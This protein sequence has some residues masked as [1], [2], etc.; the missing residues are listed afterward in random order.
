MLT[1]LSALLWDRDVLALTLAALTFAE[2]ADAQF[3]LRKA[4]SAQTDLLTIAQ[5]TRQGAFRPPLNES[6]D[7]TYGGIAYRASSDS[8]FAVSGPYG[9]SLTEISIPTLSMSTTEAVLNR[10]DRLQGPR[11]PF[12]GRIAE[13]K[14]G[15]VSEDGQMVATG[16][17]VSGSTL[18]LSGMRYYGSA[19]YSHFTRSTNLTTTTLA[20]GPMT[21]SHPL[22][23]S[24]G[25]GA[26]AEIP[27]GWR[28]ALGNKDTLSGLGPAPIITRTSQGPALFA[29]NA[30]DMI[31][32]T[33]PVPSVPLAYYTGAHPT[34]GTYQ[35]TCGVGVMYC[36][37]D[38]V[39]GIAFIDGTDTVAVI[40]QHTASDDYCYGTGTANPLLEGEPVG[41]GSFYCYD[42][43]DASKGEHGYP[44]LPWVWLY[45][46]NDLAQAAS[47]A[48]DPW[49]VVP[50]ESGPLPSID[51]AY[52]FTIKP[53]IWGVGY[54]RAGKRLFIA[55]SGGAGAQTIFH[56][57]T[58]P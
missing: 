57:V 10:A 1:L 42:P 27:A 52:P 35:G 12:E 37:T 13:L 32:G 49:D 2:P 54:D 46:A 8:L 34:L 20:Q 11:S 21:V 48:I 3:R 30:S 6:F 50:Y 16:V 7:Y 44:Y 40:G 26:M 17:L 31:A 29:W 41:D 22:N 15:Y 5:L 53:G 28:A 25:A 9:G 36:T 33:T 38:V 58:H 23:A 19:D 47:G 43:L 39:G 4:P 51:T 18:L 14:T 45:D 24:F 56:V 55:S